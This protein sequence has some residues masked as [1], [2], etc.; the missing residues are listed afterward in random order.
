MIKYSLCERRFPES[1]PLRGVSCDEDGDFL[2]GEVPLTV[3][4]FDEDARMDYGCRPSPE[5]NF[6]F[7]NAYGSDVDFSDRIA[8]LRSIARHMNNGKWVVA[9]IATVHLRLPDL[10][11]DRARA[12]LLKASVQLML[13]DREGCQ[14]GCPSVARKRDV[15]N[16]PRVPA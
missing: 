16:E 14:C 8:P 13:L 11:D 10:R 7:L 12:R 4:S 2:A 5:I 9:K 15:S 3:K 1:M 6:L